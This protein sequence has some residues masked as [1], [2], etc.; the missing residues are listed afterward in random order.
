MSLWE[1]LKH[2]LRANYIILLPVILFSL[3]VSVC[4][5]DISTANLVPSQP[6]IGFTFWQY[7]AMNQKQL[8]TLLETVAKSGISYVHGEVSWKRCELQTGDYDFSHYDV[9]FSL[10]KKHRIKIY[11]SLGAGIN[12][13][14]GQMPVFYRPSNNSKL[15]DKVS[16]FDLRKAYHRKTGKMSIQTMGKIKNPRVTFSDTFFLEREE[17]WI[18]ATITWIESKYSDVVVGYSM[19]NEP[20][21][22]EFLPEVV[23]YSDSNRRTFIRWLKQKYISIESLNATW[24]QAGVYEYQLSSF[25]EIYI[26]KLPF[27]SFDRLHFA[28]LKTTPRAWVDFQDFMRNDYLAGYLLSRLKL[29]KELAPAKLTFIKCPNRFQYGGWFKRR[30]LC[31]DIIAK[32]A[33][34]P[35]LDILGV[36]IYSTDIDGCKYAFS[37]IATIAQRYNKKWGIF[38]LG[39]PGSH[40]GVIVAE[41]IRYANAYGPTCIFAYKLIDTHQQKGYYS[42]KSGPIQP[43][44]SAIAAVSKELNG[45]TVAI[46][47][48]EVAL[49]YPT[50]VSYHRGDMSLMRSLHAILANLGIKL[51]LLYDY[52]IRDNKR[53]LSNFK[54]L[55][56]ANAQIL[57]RD[58]ED[59]SVLESLNEYVQDGG[60]IIFEGVYDRLT[61]DLADIPVM[62]TNSVFY[63]FPVSIAPIRP[64]KQKIRIQLDKLMLK[65]NSRLK[66][67]GKDELIHFEAKNE[68]QVLGVYERS[69]EPAIVISKDGNVVM[70]G[71]R[72]DSKSRIQILR[73]IFTEWGLTTLTV[74]RK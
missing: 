73:N 18:R 26:P 2:K 11:L 5:G 39:I 61:A 4:R 70:I 57:R 19:T 40:R 41:M 62:S 42:L 23:D 65:K 21:V 20:W 66:T 30:T 35:F 33:A 48:P 14:T 72:L 67:S 54:A 3:V 37:S 51:T 13:G 68:A 38:E 16:H 71:A 58:L 22:I 32:L 34:S 44:F 7:S 15:S 29:I 53:L 28:E 55:V 56:V 12:G 10:M 46:P 27:K 74:E 63:A 17:K 45:K 52:E 8:D 6:H 24:S 25:E 47:K 31:D 60:K 43:E 59:T 50:Y 49:I 69:K 9:V 36:D 1:R 64:K